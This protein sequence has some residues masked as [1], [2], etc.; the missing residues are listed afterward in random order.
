MKFLYLLSVMLM[1]TTAGCASKKSELDKLWDQGYGY[2][3]P[4]AEKIMNRNSH[5]SDGN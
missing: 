4:N 1:L 2:N 5:R 3:N